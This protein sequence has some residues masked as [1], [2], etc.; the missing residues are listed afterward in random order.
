LPFDDLLST[1]PFL[2]GSSNEDR[3][4]PQFLVADP[5]L[6][7]NRCRMRRVEKELG[8]RWQAKDVGII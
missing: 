1:S 5:F 8:C 2:D 6:V 3:L 7:T 4:T